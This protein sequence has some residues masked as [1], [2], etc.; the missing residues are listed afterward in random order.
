MQDFSINSIPETGKSKGL[1][2]LTAH[3]SVIFALAYGPR[4]RTGGGCCT[5]SGFPAD[6]TSSRAEEEDLG[7]KASVVVLSALLL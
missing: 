2:G 5:N 7:L 6:R 4:R 3:P 1:Q